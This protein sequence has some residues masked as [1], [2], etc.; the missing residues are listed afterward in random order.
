[1]AGRR[2]VSRSQCFP[3]HITFCGGELIYIYFQILEHLLLLRQ[4]VFRLNWMLDSD[5]PT[6][7]K[8]D[9]ESILLKLGRD[10]TAIMRPAF[11]DCIL[12]LQPPHCVI[13][14][15]ERE[16]LI[17]AAEIADR[18]LAGAVDCL[19]Q[20]VE[21]P[22]SFS[23]IRALRV[24]LGVV[25]EELMERD[26]FELLQEFWQ[27]GSCS[28]ET[29]LVDVFGSLSDEI[30]SHFSIGPPPPTPSD[31]LAQMFRAAGDIIA[32]LIRI[33]PTYPL[34]GR[35][36]RAFTAAAANI[37]VCT[38]LADILF[39]QTSPACIAAQDVR[40][41]CVSSIRSL[42]EIPGML[43]GGKSNAQMVLH[44]LLEHG[45]HSGCHEPVREH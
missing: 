8:M 29:C 17:R 43:P 14:H 26:E 1:M 13:T 2:W 23:Y 12:S 42:A 28:L 21:Q 20:P 37:F 22:P 15:E 7:G 40:Q 5:V 33:V 36:L 31:V 4:M 19:L 27:E 6:K 9:A 38:D 44:T 34:L 10:P 35:A 3:H 11:T 24:A 18:G 39:S 41:A 45:V 25:T 16:S 32:I 30:G